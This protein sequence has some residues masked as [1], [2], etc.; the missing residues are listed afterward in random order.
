[1]SY[2]IDLLMNL[3]KLK[4]DGFSLKEALAF[5]TTVSLR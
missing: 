4:K 3:L 1:M 2:F 5:K